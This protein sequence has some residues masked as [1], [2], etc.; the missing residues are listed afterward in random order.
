MRYPFLLLFVFS[1]LNSLA[2]CQEIYSKAYG[3]P[4]NPS[5][6]FIHGGPRGNATL[7]EGTTAGLIAKKGYY[8]IVYDRRGEGRSIDSSAA[9]TFTEAINDL[10]QLMEKYKI[11]KTSIIGHSF[12]GIV[13]TLY[14]S[15]R[16]E[17][18]ERL[19]L[20]DALFSQQETYDHILRSITKLARAKEDTASLRSISLISS[21]DR[22]SADYRKL[23]YD[24]ASTY[25]YF[26]MP[27]PTSESKQLE[28][29]YQN[30]EYGRT[31]IR[32]DKAPLL[33][34]KNERQV[35][36]DIKK[37][38]IGIQKTKVKLFGIYGRQD[39]IFSR[40]QLADIRQLIGDK[41]FDLIDNC[42]HYPFVDQQQR[43]ID[44]IKKFMM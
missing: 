17:K 42:S 1:L 33:F 12:G 25:G 30:S 43:F 13:A 39:Q 36:I 21:L 4:K 20:V 28:L 38:L 7:F 31:N 32:N 24:L 29:H 23:C 14:A 15:A 44:D 9:I 6:I 2:Q 10:D 19:I 11:E 41:R 18:V 27:Y 8:V 22:R 26:N 3:N 40:K 35:N 34:Y 16:S 5:I 37:K